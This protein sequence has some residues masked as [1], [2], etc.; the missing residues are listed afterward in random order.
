MCRTEDAERL[1][2]DH[3]TVILEL[4]LASN[5]LFGILCGEDENDTTTP[6]CIVHQYT[7]HSSVTYEE[8]LRLVLNCPE[9]DEDHRN[10]RK[11]AFLAMRNTLTHYHVL[12][13]M[14]DAPERDPLGTIPEEYFER[15][16]PPPRGPRLAN[17]F[18]CKICS[19]WL[20]G[21]AQIEDHLKGSKH[22]KKLGRAQL[23]QSVRAQTF[24][25][26][27]AHLEPRTS[28]QHE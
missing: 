19:M 25:D 14:T 6:Y 15:Q 5:M 18:L 3:E 21:P 2:Q 10:L 20:N 27:R 13:P 22:L 26:I 9:L 11:L 12:A 17:A 7:K 23:G 16:P 28:D 4:T 24:P 1:V 8:S